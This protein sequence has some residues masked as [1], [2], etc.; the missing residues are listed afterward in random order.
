M[1]SDSAKFHTLQL[2]VWRSTDPESTLDG[3]S[4]AGA[5]YAHVLSD[6]A[7]NKLTLGAGHR[8]ELRAYDRAPTDAGCMELGKWDVV[9]ELPPR[10]RK[11]RPCIVVD[12]VPVD[13]VR[14][15]QQRA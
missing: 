14:F 9:W 13:M 4:E 7:A 11:E 10:C 12:D 6:I 1:N 15:V 5:K 8:L 2:F 3:I